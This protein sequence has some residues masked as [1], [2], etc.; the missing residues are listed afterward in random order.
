MHFPQE[1]L[2]DN[3]DF[4]NQAINCSNH[5]VDNHIGGP[6]GA[7]IVKDGVIISEAWNT[8]TADNDPTAHAE[9]NAIRK[10]CKY[11]NTFKLSGCVIYTNCEPCPMCLS[12]IYW[13]RIE[14]IYYATTRVDAADINFDDNFIYE[15]I[16]LPFDKRKIPIEQIGREK[17]IETFRKWNISQNKIE[18]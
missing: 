11:L 15:E 2:S 14:K 12:A 5:S 9:M 6:F 1:S 16:N 3:I 4:M 8:V 13:S 18:Y 10:A 17:A 7:V